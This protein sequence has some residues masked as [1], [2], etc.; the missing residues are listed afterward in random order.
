MSDDVTVIETIGNRLIGKAP[1][2]L[3][4]LIQLHGCGLLSVRELIGDHSCMQSSQVQLVIKLEPDTQYERDPLATNRITTTIMDIELPQISIP[5]PTPRNL[6][7]I[8][9]LLVRK[10]I[11]QK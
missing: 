8:I 2:K 6:P 4:G 11:A 3:S 5:L 9:E 1:A 10:E 7:L